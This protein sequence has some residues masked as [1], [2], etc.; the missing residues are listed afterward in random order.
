MLW[1]VQFVSAGVGK[2]FFARFR[3]AMDLG[4]HHKIS[5]SPFAGAVL[6]NGVVLVFIILFIQKRPAGGLFAGFK[7]RA[8]WRK[9]N[10]D[11]GS[12]SLFDAKWA[13]YGFFGTSGCFWVHPAGAL[14]YSCRPGSALAFVGLPRH[15]LVFGKITRFATR[16]LA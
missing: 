7:G 12:D 9:E 2:P 6:G 4:Y 3:G 10:Y 11:D 15:R 8:G 1:H 16:L 13:G 5:W 14:N